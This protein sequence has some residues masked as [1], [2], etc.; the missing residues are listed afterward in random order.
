MKLQAHSL[1]LILF[2]LTEFLIPK[3]IR[4]TEI[5]ELCIAVFNSNIACEIAALK[6]IKRNK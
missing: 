2:W 1:N 5:A 6:I 4:L 3:V